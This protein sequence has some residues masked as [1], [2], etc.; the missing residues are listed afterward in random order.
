MSDGLR[1]ILDG[2]IESAEKGIKGALLEWGSAVVPQG[3]TLGDAFE[4]QV[5]FLAR[6]HKQ[7]VWEIVDLLFSSTDSETFLLRLQV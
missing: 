7:S 3:H 2:R 1:D 6:K 4:L 5:R